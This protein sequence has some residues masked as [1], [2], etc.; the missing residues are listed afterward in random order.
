MVNI[1]FKLLLVL[2]RHISD[3]EDEGKR[4]PDGLACIKMEILLMGILFA[5]RVV[6]P[7]SEPEILTV[8]CQ[9]TLPFIAPPPNSTVCSDWPASFTP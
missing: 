1:R 4:S 8:N 7:I 2:H 3:E 6:A 9:I 5:C